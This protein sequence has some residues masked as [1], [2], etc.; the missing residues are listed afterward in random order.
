[1][2]EVTASPSLGDNPN[3]SDWLDLSRPGKVVLRTGKVEI[4]Q[5]I[6]TA[7]VQIAADELDISPERFEVLSGHTR[8]GPPEAQ[9]SSSLSIEVTGRAVRLAAAA[10]RQRL[11]DEA[12]TLLQAQKSDIEI[13][14]GAILA[15]GR[16]TPLTLWSLAERVDLDIAVMDFAAPKPIGERRLIGTP[17]PR[18]DLLEKAV[19]PAFI[20]DITLPGLLHGRV[21]QPPSPRSR[22]RSFDE[23]AFRTRL[24]DVKLVRDGSF[25]GVIAADEEDA[26]RAIAGAAQVAEWD[27]GAAA[28]ADIVAAIGADDAAETLS[29]AVGDVDRA[30]GRRIALSARKAF[31]AHASIAPSCAIA[32]WR[33]GRLEV[34]A[35]SQGPHGLR[36]ALALVFGLDAHRDVTVV[37]KPSAGTYGHSG[38]DDVALD[39]ALLARAAAGTPVRVLW[40]RAD[41]FVAAPLGPGMVVKARATLGEDGKLAA[42]EMTSH[43]QP[44]AQ[45]PGRGGVAGLTAAELI[46]PPFP[47]VSADDVPIARGGGADRNAPPLYAVPNVRVA[48]RIAKDLPIRTS[49]LRGLGAIINVFTLE[50]LMDEAAA[51]AGADPIE[52]RLRHLEDARAK[53]VIEKAAA[54]ANWPGSLSSLGSGTGLGLGFAQYKN[55]SAYCAVVARVALDADVRLT[56]VWAAVDAGEAINPDGL[57]N[58]VEGGIIQAASMTLKEEISWHGDRVTTTSWSDYPILKFSEIPLIEVAVIDRPELAPLGAGETSIGPAAAAI[59]NAV[60]R[61]LGARV[62]SMPINRQAIL[63]AST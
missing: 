52:F 3:C 32:T 11:M 24:P 29:V 16:E 4:G 17:Y 46:E 34:L 22:L 13:H 26:V 39:A 48:K 10:V 37:H 31:T 42:L 20:Q 15:G 30:V 44:H 54:M 9:T 50:A 53:A 14:D 1:M 5:G 43:S 51:A 61:G 27:D 49:A 21:L 23:Q 45:R 25:V 2:I 38:Q 59:G 60:S 40:S 12:A 57:A 56:Q 36:D 62:T 47:W 7:L 8:L 35:H 58:Q 19:M 33:D 63:A 18:R 41:D 6:L 28:P 55:K